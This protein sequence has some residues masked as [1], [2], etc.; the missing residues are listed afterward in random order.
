MSNKPKII[1]DAELAYYTENAT[2]QPHIDRIHDSPIW[3]EGL[4][5]AHTQVVLLNYASKLRILVKT[6]LQRITTIETSC[7]ELQLLRTSIAQISNKSINPFNSASD[8]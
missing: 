6:L 2:T 4:K 1:V 3:Q 8:V 7:K 5:E